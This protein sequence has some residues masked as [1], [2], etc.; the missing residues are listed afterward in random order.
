MMNKTQAIVLAGLMLV[1]AAACAEEPTPT[2]IPYHAIPLPPYF[3]DFDC[4]D[5][6]TQWEAQRFYVQW[7]GPYRDPHNLDSDHDGIAC[8]SLD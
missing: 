5:F 6:H 3:P 1:L 8:E 4:V 2:P 7:G